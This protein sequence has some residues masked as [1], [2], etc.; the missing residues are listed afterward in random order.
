MGAQRFPANLQSDWGQIRDSL[1][2]LARIYQLP[3]LAILE[4]PGGGRGGRGA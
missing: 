2:N 4:A 3:Q 1:N